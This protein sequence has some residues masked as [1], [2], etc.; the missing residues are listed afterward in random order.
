MSKL[1]CYTNHSAK[2]WISDSQRHNQT[3]VKQIDDII[4]AMRNGDHSIKKF[5][6]SAPRLAEE[7]AL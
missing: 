6:W 4:W 2:S 5:R 3:S 7:G 1:W